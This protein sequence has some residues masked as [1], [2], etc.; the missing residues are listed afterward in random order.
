LWFIA[1]REGER[2]FRLETIDLRAQLVS[3]RHL[4]ERLLDALRKH[5][6]DTVTPAR[7][8][9]LARLGESRDFASTDELSRWFFSIFDFPK[10]TDDSVLRAAIGRGTERAFGYV[11]AAEVKNGMLE[12]GRR[13]LV[14]FGAQTPLDEIDLGPD[15]Y[16]LSPHLAT[17]LR[18]EEKPSLE[19]DAPADGAAASPADSSGTAESTN[20]APTY[21]LRFEATAAQLF[22]VLP[23]LQNLAERSARFVARLEVEAEGKEPFDPNWLRNAV[24]EHLD[25]AGIDVTSARAAE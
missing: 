9:A 13:D 22:R 8:V 20:G 12:V 24:E 19:P 1:D 7:I 5:V 17:T 11:S 14:R 6:F 10:L 23:A 18:G 21:A 4:H 2:P 3:G 16:V 15:C 25:E